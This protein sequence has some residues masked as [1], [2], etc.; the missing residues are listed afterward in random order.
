MRNVS[1]ALFTIGLLSLSS[2]QTYHY[3]ITDNQTGK[4]FYK[5]LPTPPYKLP[6][7]IALTDPR[8]G[9]VTVTTS[10]TVDP[11]SEAEYDLHRPIYVPR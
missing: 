9:G 5:T 7:S 3:R 8:T 6:A 1:A 4:T 2:C 11:I 10:Y